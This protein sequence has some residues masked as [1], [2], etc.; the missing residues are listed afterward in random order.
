MANRQES[1]AKPRSSAAVQR[2]VREDTI[3]L[4]RGHGMT[5]VFG[6][7]GSTELKFFHGA[8]RLRR[9]EGARHR[10]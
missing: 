9:S 5:V 4:L 2:S 1:R 3:D 6:N 10:P 8:R 7:P